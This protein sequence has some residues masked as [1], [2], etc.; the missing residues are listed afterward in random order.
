MQLT[1][2]GTKR[3]VT[4]MWTTKNI[5]LFVGNPFSAVL[6]CAV[7]G[8][9]KLPLTKIFTIF[10]VP[11]SLFVRPIF[12]SS[13]FLIPTYF[14]IYTNYHFTYIHH[15]NSRNIQHTQLSSNK[16]CNIPHNHYHNIHNH[17][18]NYNIRCRTQSNNN[19]LSKHTNRPDHH[20]TLIEFVA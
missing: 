1:L 10:K 14:F 19:M 6:Y 16:Y 13:F 9:G 17:H 11:L 20:L 7:K 3:T 8:N 12:H 18:S 2:D 15:N 4:L 5:Y